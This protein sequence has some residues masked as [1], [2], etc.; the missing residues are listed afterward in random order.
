MV[1]ARGEILGQARVGVRRADHREVLR[2]RARNLGL[3]HRGVVGPDHAQELGVAKHAGH[4]LHAGVR[5]VSGLAAVV[6]GHELDREAAHASS[7][8]LLLDREIDAVLS[9]LTTG[10]TCRKVG[11]D[12]DRALGAAPSGGAATGKGDQGRHREDYQS[13]RSNHIFPLVING[14]QS[15]PAQSHTPPNTRRPLP[16]LSRG[17]SAP[18]A[19]AATWG[20]RTATPPRT[21]DLPGPASQVGVL[22]GAS[23]WKFLGVVDLAHEGPGGLRISG[24]RLVNGQ[25]S[26]RGV[27]GRVEPDRARGA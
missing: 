13:S 20:G 15:A 3:G 8:V 7:R 17:E 10:G 22:R 19:S 18:A 2:R 27:P 23:I 12:L 26:M 6:E 9:R 4:V 21:I 1:A 16:N 11:T 25:R 5:R 24:G 14:R